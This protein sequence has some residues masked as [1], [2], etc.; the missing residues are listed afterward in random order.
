MMAWLNIVAIIL[1]RKPALKAFKDYERQRK[2]GKDPV[3]MPK[4]PV[5]NIQTNGKLILL[6][7]RHFE[8]S[9]AT[10]NLGLIN[11]FLLGEEPR[12]K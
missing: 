9:A 11:R 7:C 3:L 1:L 12:S 2:A 6:Y 10:R 4:K 8:G 5:L